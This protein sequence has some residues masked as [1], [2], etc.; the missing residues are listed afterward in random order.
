M[1]VLYLCQGELNRLRRFWFGR[2]LT[3]GP[4]TATMMGSLP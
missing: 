1:V 4:E 2:E 3:L